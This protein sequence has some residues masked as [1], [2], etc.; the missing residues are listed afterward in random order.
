MRNAIK[1]S[2]I[3]VE[4]PGEDA[5]VERKRKERDAIKSMKKT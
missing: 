5:I 1:A 3:K 2:V 4:A